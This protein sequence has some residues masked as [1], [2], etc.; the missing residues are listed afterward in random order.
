MFHKWRTWVA[1]PTRACCR[2]D[3]VKPLFEASLYDPQ[4]DGIVSGDKRS[5]RKNT[6]SMKGA[7]PDMLSA[8]KFKCCFL[9]LA[10]VVFLQKYWRALRHL[11][12]SSLCF[13]NIII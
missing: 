2:G 5:C 11:G 10:F 4:V 6:T 9:R 8:T 3:Y 1:V 7:S 12:D 13:E